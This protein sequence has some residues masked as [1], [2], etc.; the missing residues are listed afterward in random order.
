MSQTS[1]RVGWNGELGGW[2]GRQCRGVSAF[3]LCPCYPFGAMRGKPLNAV[4]GRQV[5]FL[6]HL[7]RQPGLAYIIIV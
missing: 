2:A 7:T 4:Q 1:A 3:A 5:F 6:A